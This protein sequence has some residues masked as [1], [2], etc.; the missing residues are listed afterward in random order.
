LKEKDVDE[1]WRAHPEL[2]KEDLLNCA[3]DFQPDLAS[4]GQ[5]YWG[6]Q[7]Q[8]EFAEAGAQALGEKKVFVESLRPSE[9]RDYQPPEGI[10][11]VGDNHITRGSVFVIGGAP[12]VGKSRA[13][14]A[15]AEAGATGYEWFNLE[16]HSKFKTLIVQNEN[17]RFRLKLE[18]A[19]LDAP[20]LDEYLRITPPPPYGLCF[21]QLEFREQLAQV[22]A[23]FKPDVVIIDPWNAASHDEKAKSMLETFQYIRS[24]IPAGDNAPAIGIIAHTHK[25]KLG[26]RSSGRALLNLLAGSY[27]LG[28]VPRCVFIMQSATDDVRDDRVVWTCC[29]NNDGEL[30]KRS[31]W[32]RRNGLFDPVDD[33][34]WDGF[35]N[36]GKGDGP[37]WEDV[38]NIVADL[39]KKA[40][41]KNIISELMERG[42]SQATAYR[43]AEIAEKKKAIY[44]NQRTKIFEVR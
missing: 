9:L 34:D 2:T 18:L 6:D 41:R 38:K 19:E 30:G 29:K 22:I 21:E 37:T 39:G 23:E 1:I 32:T 15:L 42:T 25:P 11:L 31:A 40:T 27:V 16:V 4:N 13:S 3:E 36:P 33:F 35:D 20:L 44:L 8:K 14:V 43:C 12:G 7:V 24:V 5:G 28:S 26:E 17:G 10:V